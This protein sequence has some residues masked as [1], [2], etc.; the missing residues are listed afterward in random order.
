MGVALALT[1]VLAA[2]GGGQGSDDPDQLE[3]WTFKQSHVA[4][5][6][7]AAEI[8]ERETGVSVKI[9]AYTPDDAYNT[10]VAASARTNDL[11]DVLEVHANGSDFSFGGAG[12]LEDLS[13]DVTEEWTERFLPPVAQDGTVTRQ[14]YEQSLAPG[15]ATVGIQEGERYSVPFTVGTFG[16]VYANK[17]RLQQAGFTEAPETWEEFIA[18]LDAV[19]QEFPDNGGVTIGMKVPS[20]GLEWMLQPM[21][22][23]QLG[24][25][26]YPALFSED[27][28]VNWSS[29]T[30]VRT[31]ET[32][33]QVNPYWTPGTGILG[34][35]EAD[36]SFAHGESTF[37]VGGTFTLAFLAEN[38]VD[39]DNL[40]T[41]PIPPPEGA[42]L[43]DMELKPFALTGLSVVRE[44]G[45]M[46]TALE[47]VR[48]LSRDDVAREFAQ[49]AL[50]L[51]PNDLG[52]RPEEAVGPVLGAMAASLG[53][54][55]DA[56]HA[57][58]T[59]YKPN[60]YDAAD[61]GAVF[62]EFAPLARRDAER[63]GEALS[64]LINSYWAESR[65]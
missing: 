58:D 27:P 46:D 63:S 56:Y 53:E 12:L 25:D 59:S 29:P 39:P 9:Q 51:P 13:D 19:G 30:G 22:Y 61:V 43:P 4:G 8:F 23:G 24:P 17:E 32:F 37:V 31:L 65:R 34:I 2:C 64:D 11:P 33:G 35:D 5:L 6:E 55:E 15:A 3:M 1:T 41:F 16:I 42:A 45:N 20:T 14:F 44:G 38:G 50:D 52:P 48:F 57:G 60:G 18:M 7:A 28:E 47:W 26:A 40:L 62:A 49:T 21:A 36:L 54:S 10:K